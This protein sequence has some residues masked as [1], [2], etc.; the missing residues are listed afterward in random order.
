MGNGLIQVI[1]AITSCN[2]IKLAFCDVDW[3]VDNFWL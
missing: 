3:M 2:V 1:T